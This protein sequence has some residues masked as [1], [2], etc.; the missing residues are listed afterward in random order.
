MKKHTRY[1]IT[2]GSKITFGGKTYTIKNGKV[3]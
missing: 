2:I 3:I 1:L